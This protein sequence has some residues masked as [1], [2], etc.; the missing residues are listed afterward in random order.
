MSNLRLWISNGFSIYFCMMNVLNFTLLAVGFFTDWDSSLCNNKLVAACSSSF[1][2]LELICRIGGIVK[3]PDI[4]PSAG[5]CGGCYGSGLFSKSFFY[6][7]LNFFNSR[8]EQYCLISLCK[9]SKSLKTWMPRPLFKCVG[10]SIHKLY[11]SKW[12]RGMVYF[13]NFLSKLNGLDFVPPFLNSLYF[14]FSWLLTLVCSSFFSCV[15]SLFRIYAICVYNLY[16]ISL[17]WPFWASKV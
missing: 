16:S 10:L 5:D 3:A 8:P 4:I 9:V 12:Q 1:R 13:F 15:G 7:L 6:C 11:E 17:I 14:S 2:V